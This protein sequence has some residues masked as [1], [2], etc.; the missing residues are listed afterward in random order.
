LIWVEQ[1]GSF[2]KYLSEFVEFGVRLHAPESDFGEGLAS[3]G[4]SQRTAVKDGTATR[5]FGEERL[6]YPQIGRQR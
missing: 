6:G 5:L 2:D 3:V 4:S 1:K